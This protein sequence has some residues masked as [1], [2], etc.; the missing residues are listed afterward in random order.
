M[1]L[2]GEWL[3]WSLFTHR[4][5]MQ[6]TFHIPKACLR[7]LYTSAFWLLSSTFSSSFF[8]SSEDPFSF[9]PVFQLPCLF[10]IKDGDLTFWWHDD[11]TCK[12]KYLYINLCAHDQEQDPFKLS[13]TRRTKPLFCAKY[14]A[15]ANWGLTLLSMQ[16]WGQRETA[17]L[18]LSKSNKHCS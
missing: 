10:Q 17:T 2:Q 14:E 3:C 7:F 6:P 1:L 12:C 16:D 9:S 18:A 8:S 4:M 15:R 5:E 13:Q 11:N